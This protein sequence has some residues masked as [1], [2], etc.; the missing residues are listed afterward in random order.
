MGTFYR[1]ENELKTVVE[2]WSPDRKEAPPSHSRSSLSNSSEAAQ[3]T[4]T[5]T[6][7]ATRATWSTA[8]PC[9]SGPPPRLTRLARGNSVRG[10]QGSPILSPT[11]PAEKPQ[12]PP[13]PAPAAGLKAQP[14]PLPPLP[15]FSFT[16][17]APIALPPL[18]AELD[19]FGEA[20][21]GEAAAPAPDA[22]VAPTA[23]EGGP[24]FGCKPSSATTK[25]PARSMV[26]AARKVSNPPVRLASSPARAR[27]TTGP[28]QSSWTRSSPKKEPPG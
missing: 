6:A 19:G 11:R 7:P 26:G 25:T 28:V 12:P 27:G 20:A 2:V 24:A 14:V 17:V 18:P 1:L 4:W 23:A 3:G 5:A 22:A 15:T 13:A 10:L 9:K 8:D 16:S 21:G